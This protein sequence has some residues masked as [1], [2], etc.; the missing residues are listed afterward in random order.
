MSWKDSSSESEKRSGWRR[1]SQKQSAGGRSP[2]RKQSGWAQQK[3]HDYEQAALLHR[4]KIAAGA[5]LFVALAVGFGIWVFWWPVTT[6]FLVATATNYDA[7]IPPNAWARED[8]GRLM[9]LNREQVLHCV[10]VP[11][12]SKESGR[13]RLRKLFA[14]AKPGGPDRNLVVVYLSAHGLVDENNEAQRHHIV[15]L[16][17]RAD[18]CDFGTA[19]TEMAAA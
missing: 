9:Q 11:W 19:V 8:A 12:Q 13:L 17:L 16:H 2:G 14:A 5:L 7:P 18:C 3:D 1:G 6:P 15:G 10:D 4:I